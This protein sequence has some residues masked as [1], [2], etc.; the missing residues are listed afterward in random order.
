MQL[1][2]L[3]FLLM[4]KVTSEFILFLMDNVILKFI[5]IQVFSNAFQQTLSFLE[6]IVKKMSLLLLL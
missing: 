4:G 1:G 6:I 3:N 5:L 2:Q